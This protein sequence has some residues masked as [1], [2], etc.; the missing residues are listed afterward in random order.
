MS[1]GAVIV[2][3]PVERDA[4]GFWSHPNIPDF[5]ECAESYKAWL[6]DNGLVISYKYL[7]SED[8]EHPAY[9]SYFDQESCSCALWGP[10][11]PDGDGW[12]TLAIYDTEDGPVWAWAKRAADPAGGA[13]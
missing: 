13:K 10:T 5:D 7:E 9:V 6:D 2:A 4:E 3:A 8:D 11:T 1:T 12:F